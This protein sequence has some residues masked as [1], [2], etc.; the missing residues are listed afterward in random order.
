MKKSKF[1]FGVVV[2]SVTFSISVFGQTKDDAPKKVYDAELAKKLGADDYGMRSYVMV[3]LKTGPNDSKITDKTKRGE[4][5]KGH[6]ANMG[7]LAKE[8]KLVFAGPF[9]DGKPMR[10]L[11]IFNVETIEEAEALVKTDPTVK[12]GIFVYK[13]TKL[14]GSAALIQVNDIHGKI[15]KTAVN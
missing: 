8:G 6:F 7:R 14:Y 2:L 13:M 12:A 4:L 5:F 15:Q 1:I 10:G 3:V 11:Y 9:I